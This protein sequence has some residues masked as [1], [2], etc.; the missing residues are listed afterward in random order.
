MEFSK[1]SIVATDYGVSR[2]TRYDLIRRGIVPERCVIRIGSSL[3]LTRKNSGC[4]QV[5]LP[6]FPASLATYRRNEAVGG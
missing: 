1:V 2:H 4:H 5:A 3:R 6:T